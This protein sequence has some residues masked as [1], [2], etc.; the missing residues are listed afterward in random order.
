MEDSSRMEHSIVSLT[1]D[2]LLEILSRVP[3]K[4]LCRL[5]SVSKSWLALCSDP[6]VRKKAP[7][8][9]SGFFFQSYREPTFNPSNLHHH[10]T[11]L[12]GRGQP[13]V[14][15][16][17]P[18]LNFLFSANYVEVRFVHCCNDL[19]LC[20]CK[21][22]SDGECDRVVFNPATEK[23]TVL[24]KT[25]ARLGRYAMHLGF[26]PTVSSHFTVFLLSKRMRLII[27]HQVRAVEIYSSQTGRW[28]YH[29]SQW[30]EKSIEIFSSSVFYNGAL[31]VTTLDSS[32]NRVDTGG[33]I[34]RTV[35]MPYYSRFIGMSQ[36]LLYAV[37]SP[38][39]SSQLSIW[40]LKDYGGK[41]WSLKQAINSV[42]S[43][44]T[45]NIFFEDGVPPDVI[46]IH[47]ECSLV[48]MILGPRR[49]IV[50]YNIDNRKVHDICNLADQS[51]F[52]YLPYIPCFAE[53]FS[54]GH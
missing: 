44:G 41:E 1:D 12:S 31:H 35:P 2:L 46:A 49:N 14:D 51:V 52:P 16:I 33:K 40:V 7:Q 9:L 28:T 29:Q 18:S 47:P 30:G 10:F 8:T 42:E 17:D 50:S 45:H 34:W 32:V 22:S 4:S 27:H 11:N 21:E 37:Y 39:Y 20:C 15:V 38:R 23:W 6:I 25:E 3:Y 36:G 24:P 54:D 48:F 26:D 19:L 53:W 43:F 13:M 5:K